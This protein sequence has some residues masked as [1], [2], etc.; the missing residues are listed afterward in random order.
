MLHPAANLLAS[1]DKRQTFFVSPSAHLTDITRIPLPSDGDGDGDGDGESSCAAAPDAG[2]ASHSMITETSEFHRCSSDLAR[3]VIFLSMGRCIALALKHEICIG[4]RLDAAFCHRL[5]AFNVAPRPDECTDEELKAQDAAFY[6]YKYAFIRDTSIPELEAMGIELVFDDVLDDRGPSEL[7]VAG[8]EQ[9]VPL[10]P[11]SKRTAEYGADER[12]AK[13]AKIAKSA[14]TKVTDANKGEY[15]SLLKTHRLWGTARNHTHDVLEGMV[16]IISPSTLR[17][18]KSMLA[19]KFGSFSEMIA[20][21]PVLDVDDWHR[22]TEY[23]GRYTASTP[24]VTYFW[25][26]VRERLSESE[27]SSLLQFATG[28]RHPPVGGFKMLQGFNGGLH[29]F[30]LG[31]LH[32]ATSDGATRGAA[33]GATGGESETQRQ[34]LP[35]AHSCICTMD[36]P[37]WASVD[38]AEKKLRMAITHGLR[39]DE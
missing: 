11:Q 34:K 3:K 36:I 8:A 5:L 17:Q 22:H 39:F 33:G 18:L 29:K 4:I 37:E 15:L 1:R 23:V 10:V 35:E 7:R 14:T 6:K 25:R 9:R 31:P 21:L 20:G 2:A 30:S 19:P 27:R 32:G 24:V 16:S 38:E 26:V 28:S 12:V 13:V